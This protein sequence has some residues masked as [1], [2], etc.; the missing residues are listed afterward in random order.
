MYVYLQTIAVRIEDRHPTAF[1]TDLINSYRSIDDCVVMPAEAQRCLLYMLQGFGLLREEAHRNPGK[2]CDLPREDVHLNP[3]ISSDYRSSS[4]NNR[5]GKFVVK[6]GGFGPPQSVGGSFSHSHT[7]PTFKTIH[8]NADLSMYESKAQEA[9]E[10][11]PTLPTQPA[12]SFDH[13]FRAATPPGSDATIPD[14]DEP[15]VG[16]YIKHEEIEESAAIAA[17]SLYEPA[18]KDDAAN[19][20]IALPSNDA[21]DDSGIVLDDVSASETQLTDNAPAARKSSDSQ[22]GDSAYGTQLPRGRDSAS[23]GS[24]HSD[25]KGDVIKE[26]QSQPPKQS[27][28]KLVPKTGHPSRYSTRLQSVVTNTPAEH[29]SSPPKPAS[30]LRKHTRKELEDTADHETT[31]VAEPEAKRSKDSQD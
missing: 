21:H 13:S 5:E 29:A 20:D 8:P 3:A 1:F 19:R 17:Y 28:K 14:T 31:A 11:E 23:A 10:S 25:M 4:W 18:L 16:V 7:D 6:T 22:F 26:E 12:L 15:V 9:D 24:N 27:R 2:P 30:S